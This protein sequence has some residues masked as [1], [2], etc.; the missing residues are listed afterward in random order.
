VDAVMTAHV[1][2]PALDPTP[3]LPATLSAETLTGLL[4]QEMGFAGLIMTDAIG[5]KAVAGRYETAE[6]VERALRAG[7]DIILVGADPDHAVEAYEAIVTAVREGR[8][9]PERLDQSLRRILRLKWRLGLL[10]SAVVAAAGPPAEQRRPS[11]AAHR[12]V[13]LEVARAS[14]T[15]VR[16]KAGVLPLRLEPD[17]RLLVI[18]PELLRAAEG[19]VFHGAEE[20][21]AGAVT[22][23][24]PYLRRHHRAV[25]E[26]VYPAR[27]PAEAVAAAAAAAAR[28]QAVL[29]V[30]A[31]PEMRSEEAELV[32]QVLASA[33]S[34]RPVVWVSLWSP[35]DLAAV[36]SAPTFVAAYSFRQVS[37]AALA[38]A[39]FGVLPFEGRLPV[40]LPGIPSGHP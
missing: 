1:T 12:R 6:I 39:L 20:T 18:A 32:R 19:D 21:A 10:E 25:E 33:G 35:Y 11:T 38:E 4:R 5:M 34:A 15:L 36:P 30:T 28:A 16:D 14:L 37:L 9:T 2:F 13:A 7:A 17:D 27:P 26:F 24:G 3:G 8:V 31:A 29:L 40:T 22:A 23:L